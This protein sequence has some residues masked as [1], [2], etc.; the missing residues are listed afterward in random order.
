MLTNRLF[1][2][3]SFLPALHFVLKAISIRETETMYFL[4]LVVFSCA[5]LCRGWCQWTTARS[6]SGITLP[7]RRETNAF[8]V[9]TQNYFPHKSRNKQRD[10]Y[11]L[12]LLSL[13][14]GGELFQAMIQAADKRP[15][16]RLQQKVLFPIPRRKHEMDEIRNRTVRR[17]GITH[18]QRLYGE[19]TRY[20]KYRGC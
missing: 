12:P 3:L 19:P 4:M 16:Y 18:L 11:R 7:C 5:S 1:A 17:E 10:G 13:E 6:V 2:H 8:I 20:V 9:L 14:R 15:K